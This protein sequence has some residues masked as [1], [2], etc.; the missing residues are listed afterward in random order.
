MADGE[1][2]FPDVEEYVWLVDCSDHGSSW[3]TWGHGFPEGGLAPFV[4]DTRS[5]LLDVLDG[6]ITAAAG[7]EVDFDD[8]PTWIRASAWRLGRIVHGGL[9]TTTPAEVKSA[10]QYGWW[11]HGNSIAPDAVE[12]R[13]P[14]QVVRLVDEARLK[15]PLRREP[16]A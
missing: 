16:S 13:T 10:T 2:H 3:R 8:H 4:D 5:L 6:W 12:V 9:V 7:A 14:H 1:R 15:L 11:L